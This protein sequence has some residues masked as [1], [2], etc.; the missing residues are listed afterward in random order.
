MPDG[1]GN[2]YFW[3]KPPRIVAGR[4]GPDRRRPA[5]P[6]RRR[7]APVRRGRGP[8]GRAVRSATA[9]VARRRRLLPALLRQPGPR[10]ADARRSWPRSTRRRSVSLVQRGA[11]RVP[12]VRAGHDHAGRR[13]RQAA[14][15]PPT[16]PIA[17]AS[18]SCPPT[19]L[20]SR[21]PLPAGAVLHHEVQRRG[22][23]GR[24]GR[25]PAGHDRAVR[26]GGRGAGR[27]LVTR[28]AGFERVLTLDGGG[29]STDVSV[30]LGGEPTLTTEGTRR[31]LP[32]QDPDDRHRHRGRG[33]R[34]GRLAV[35]RG[36]AQ[37]RPALGRGRPGPAV[38]RPGRHRADRDRRP[39]G[40]GADPAPPARRRGAAGPGRRRGPGWRRWGRA[41]PGPGAAWP[42]AILE[43]S[44][45]NQANA[46][47][48]VTVQ[49]GLDVR[50]FALATFGG[51][52]SLLLCRL[53]DIARR[54][55]RRRAPRPGQPVGVRAADRRRQ[56]RPRADARVARHADLD[57]ADRR[58]HLGR[59]PGTGRAAPWTPRASPAPTQRFLRSADLRYFGQ[60]F[61]VRVPVRRRR[62][63]HRPDRGRRGR[64]PRRPR[65]PLR[66]LL[67][68]RARAAGRVGE[69][70]G[71]RRRPD[72]PPRR[73][74]PSAPG[75]H[76]RPA[77]PRPVCFDPSSGF[78]A[79]ADLLAGRPAGRATWSTGRRS[80]RSTARPCRCTP[81]SRPTVDRLGNLVVRR[82]ET[83]RR[84]ARP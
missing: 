84:P 57:L 7:A 50:D 78:V 71:H 3:V 69:P 44:A 29:T 4:P 74:R 72:P 37:G 68:G 62:R 26:A 38:L 15:R 30:V 54:A 25:A 14:G 51:S 35:P 31:R 79:D 70:A 43:I 41:R 56:D 42:P 73:C 63:R 80:S 10:A 2:S 39:P 45:W 22:A 23:V 82:S 47:R 65:A 59:A 60:A 24:R 81:G 12:R 53:I 13:R 21:R 76:G 83:A 58:R 20:P 75:V 36:R 16:S 6:H 55:G 49:R 18:R 19:G 32:V 1:Y 40:A 52:G 34:V 5:R 33:R 9:E 77:G 46:L 8:R 64:L 17:C 28:A 66:L 48:Q 61:E 11:A 67:P 27:G